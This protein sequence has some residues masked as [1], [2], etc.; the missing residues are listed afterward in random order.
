LSGLPARCDAAAGAGDKF[1]QNIA[2]SEMDHL[3]GSTVDLK[4]VPGLHEWLLRKVLPCISKDAVVMD[5]GCGDGIWLQKLHSAGF[6]NLVG[7][8]RDAESFAATDIARFIHADLD[9][10][11]QLPGLSAGLITAI[12]VVEHVQNPTNLLKF[13]ASC[14]APAGWLIVTTPNIYSLRTRL[15]FLLNAHLMFFD[16]DCNT[17]HLHPYIAGAMTRVVLDPLGL[18]I[19]RQQTFPEDRSEISRP[20]ARL[21]LKTLSLAVPDK[22]PGDSLCL[23][24]RKA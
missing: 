22:L 2:G 23:I 4:S 10:E 9:N 13:A 14:L 16:R 5:L 1:A 17:E 6:R 21:M 3:P 11:Q 24:I 8:D 18:Q 12:E 15:R 7:I 19:V 20:L